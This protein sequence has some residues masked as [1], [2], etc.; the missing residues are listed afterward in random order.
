[1][2]VGP[3][4]L[5]QVVIRAQVLIDPHTMQMTIASDPLPRIV[6]GIPL[7]L[8]TVNL[9]I[10]RP[11]FVFNPTSCASQLI[12]GTVT[13]GE[14]ASAQ[15]SSP[16]HVTGCSGLA[17]APKLTA[18]TRA[19]ASSEG[20]GA[21]LSVRVADPAGK[22]ANIRSV[23]VDLPSQLRPRLSAIQK[24]CPVA[25]FDAKPA[26]CPSG[27][28]VGS[29]TVATPVLSAPLHGYTYLVDPGPS[30]PALLMTQLQSQG[31]VV[32]LSGAIHIS[33]R[34]VISTAFKNL[35][36]V[37][38]SSFLLELS[39]GPDSLLGAV[40]GLCSRKL[41]MPYTLAAENGALLERTLGVSVD[42]CPGRRGRRARAH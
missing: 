22:E 35:P 11:G 8:R 18:S 37:P 36:D 40:E 21:G 19:K 38:I 6:D 25:R 32:E 16:F 4:D 26:S 15:V 10:D 30:A 2:T 5:S 27:S 14:G 3:F 17:F 42:G 28:R 31:V 39:P 33:G 9:T 41:E 12:A 13:S 1:M 23:L 20:G 29:M 24:A 7:R 34:G